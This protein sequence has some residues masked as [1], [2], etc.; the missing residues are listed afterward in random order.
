MSC[1]K[2]EDYL[3]DRLD[4]ATFKIHMESCEDC[5]KAYQVDARIMDRSRKLN[6]NLAIP[7]LWPS[8]EKGIQKKKPV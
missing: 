8:I 7:D 5:R 1:N 2:F 4:L 6:D 3:N